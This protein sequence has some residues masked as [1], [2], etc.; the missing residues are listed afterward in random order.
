MAETT[1]QRKFKEFNKA[2]DKRD[3]I[4]IKDEFQATR[5][6]QKLREMSDDPVAAKRAI[7]Q[8]NQTAQALRA[9]QSGNTAAPTENDM[10]TPAMA[11]APAVA[12]MKKGGAIKTKKM[13]KGG[14]TASSRADGCCTKGKTKGR[15]C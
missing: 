6:A 10:S 12:P 4:K 7:D 15:I 2:Q 14:M 3:A 8:S 13:A 5:D 9:M 11:P 1:R